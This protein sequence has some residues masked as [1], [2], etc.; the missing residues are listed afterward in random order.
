VMAMG[1]VMKESRVV[2]V[3]IAAISR[4]SPPISRAKV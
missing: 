2:A 1:M 4:V 3:M